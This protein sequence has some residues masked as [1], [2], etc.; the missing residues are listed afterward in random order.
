MLAGCTQSSAAPA[1]GGSFSGPTS[2][3]VDLDPHTGATFPVSSSDTY[4]IPSVINL[5]YVLNIAHVF[6][7]LYG[8]TVRIFKGGGAPVVNGSEWRSRI[9]SMATKAQIEREQKKWSDPAEA[10]LSLRE[11][12]GDPVT[13]IE[14]VVQASRSCIYLKVLTDN[15]A[16]VNSG[17]TATNTSEQI[18]VLVLKKQG[19]VDYG[20]NPTPWVINYLAAINDGKVPNNICSQS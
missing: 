18:E 20:F 11:I 14:K 19:S 10:A 9:Y 17:S 1:I 15:R 7:H 5:T 6:D 8:D 12:P 3:I 4:A 16:V 13:N 2:S